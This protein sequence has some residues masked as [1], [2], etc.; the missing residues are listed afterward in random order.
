MATAIR[1]F[2]RAGQRGQTKLTHHAVTC[3][4]RSIERRKE[5]RSIGSF[6]TSRTSKTR[7]TFNTSINKAGPCAGACECSF[8]HGFLCRTKKSSSTMKQM[9]HVLA[10]GAAALV[11]MASAVSL[12][13]AGHGF[14]GGGFGGHG[15]GGGGFGGHA[16]SSGGFGGRSFGGGHISSFGHSYGNYGHSFSSR[17]YGNYGRHYAHNDHDG[18]HDHHFHHGRGV[19][20]GYGFYDGYY[21]GDYYGYGRGCG[22]LYRR[23]VV[24]GSPYWWNRYQNCIGYD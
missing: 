17:S 10:I 20:V 11:A 7:L 6:R 8:R 19:F 22:W 5:K 16:F 21:D 18:H 4:L 23:A 3:A 1:D 14:G 9:K 12:A 15:F 2:Y 13:E 24:T